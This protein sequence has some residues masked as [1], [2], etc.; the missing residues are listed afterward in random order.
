MGN[1]LKELHDRLL[2]E[3]PD[4]APHDE[5][6]CPMCAMENSDSNNNGGGASSTTLEGGS[7]TTT[8]T[9]EQL[10]AAVKEAAEKAVA[11]A[12][13][14][15]QEK[16]SA[17]EAAQADSEVGKA[18]AEAT[19]PLNEQITALQTQLDEAVLA[20]TAA[21]EAKAATEQFWTDAIAEHESAEAA[22]ARKDERLAKVKEATNFP[23]DYLTENAARFAAMSDEDFEAR[24]GEWSAIA[25]KADATIPVTTNL[26][27]ARDAAVNAN[28]GS[29]LGE[30]RNLRGLS[31][32]RTLN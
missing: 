7:M 6:T 21:D 14:P 29:A 13:A 3:K 20:K 17:F 12:T 18:V 31:D 9:Q 1:A 16:I 19:A 30:L 28:S 27:A 4:D 11:E 24:L 2:A 8:Y 26:Q 32:P 15:L 10:E 25:P 5:A 22:A 23:E